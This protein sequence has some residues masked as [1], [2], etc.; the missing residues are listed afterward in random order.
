MEE[1]SGL[2]GIPFWLQTFSSE[3]TTWN[4]PVFW[5]WVIRIS[6]C[7]L[8]YPC[9][10]FEEEKY[11]LVQ[12]D[13]GGEISWRKILVKI[14]GVLYLPAEVGL[15]K[16]KRMYRFV[17]NSAKLLLSIEMLMTVLP[18][19]EREAALKDSTFG[20]LANRPIRYY[21]LLKRSIL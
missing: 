12:V 15:S 7:E 9:L 17:K 20:Q 11:S 8:C 13:L 10:N 16:W 3:T 14:T 4:T 19:F 2:D 18:K 5:A 21:A 1:G 6:D